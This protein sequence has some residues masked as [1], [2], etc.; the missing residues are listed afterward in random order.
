MS[1]RKNKY[2]VLKILFFYTHL[3][4]LLGR[5]CGFLSF[6]FHVTSSNSGFLCQVSIC[7]L[8]A[9]SPHPQK[10]STNWLHNSDPEI[11]RVL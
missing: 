8:I 6:A 5:G 11:Q 4:N 7:M 1:K 10:Y 3:K 9:F 2:L